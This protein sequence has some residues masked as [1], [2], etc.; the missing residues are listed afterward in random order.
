MKP[1]GRNAQLEL[2]RQKRQHEREIFEGELGWLGKTFGGHKEKPGNISAIVILVCLLFLA[3]TYGVDTYVAVKYSGQGIAPIPPV[4]PFE[5][6]FGGLTAI[7]TLI[8]GY[9][10]GSHDSISR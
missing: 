5:H 6:I 7:V 1:Q 10:F 8:L 3:L 9:L 4:M 2:D